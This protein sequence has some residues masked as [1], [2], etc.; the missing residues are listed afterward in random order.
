MPTHEH[1][2]VGARAHVRLRREQRGR[3]DL[4][5]ARHP[6]FVRV[7]VVGEGRALEP[8]ALVVVAERLLGVADVEKRLAEAEMQR[9][10]IGERDPLARQ[11]RLHLADQRIARLEALEVGLAEQD[12]RRI[13]EGLRRL[14]DRL[15][16][17]RPCGRTP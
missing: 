4:G 12:P 3:E 11:Q 17:P 14:L 13:G 9:R 10:A 15:H 7:R 6:A 8:V 5:D 2:Q 1:R 16:A